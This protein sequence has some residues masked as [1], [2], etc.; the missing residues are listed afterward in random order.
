MIRGLFRLRRGTNKEHLSVSVIIPARNEMQGI[1]RCLDAVL[2]QQYPAH[3]YEI[4]VVDDR[5]TDATATIVETYACQNACIKLVSLTDTTEGIAG[6]K[7]AVACGIAQASHDIIIVTDADCNPQPGWIAGMISCFEPDVGVVAGATF[8][9]RA[10]ETSLWVKLLSIENV[11]LIAAGAGSIGAAR[12]SI[13]NGSNL[14]YRKK[15]FTEVGGFSGI[16]HIASGD[17]DMFIQK[18]SKI[19]RWRSAFS[20]SKTTYNYTSPPQGLREFI[21]QRVRW[22][23]KGGQYPDRLLSFYLSV[24]YV[25]YIVCMVALA[26]VVLHPAQSGGLLLLLAIKFSAET[27]VAVQ[28]CR[29]FGRKRLIPF[30]PL[31]GALFMP[32]VIGI[33]TLGMFKAFRWKE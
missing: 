24:M 7:R 3:R 23:S 10:Y 12:P 14:A 20:T 28:G 5:S 26:M 33:S 29:L 8:F 19:T 15:V 11:A 25:Y 21:N 9:K 16:D 27:V 18:V 6:K 22:S 13:C 31:L 17:D 4:V 32:Y 30:I 1:G 2:Q